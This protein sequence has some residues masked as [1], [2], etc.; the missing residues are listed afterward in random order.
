MIAKWSFHSDVSWVNISFKYQFSISRHLKIYCL[1][2]YCLNSG[3]SCNSSKDILVKS[4][5]DWRYCRKYGSRVCTNYYCHF[6]FA[7]GIFLDIIMICSTFMLLPVHK[8][9]GFV[10][11]LHSINTKVSY[12]CL[13]ML[14]CH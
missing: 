4:F 5:W 7:S 12:F 14:C 13:W 9:V 8:S 1:A 3:L 11:D 6:N 2:F 10:E